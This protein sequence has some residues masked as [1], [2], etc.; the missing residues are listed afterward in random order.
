MSVLDSLGGKWVGRNART[1]VAL[2]FGS[3]VSGHWYD[4]AIPG[5]NEFVRDLV[6]KAR[7]NQNALYRDA[8]TVRMHYEDSITDQFDALEDNFNRQLFLLRGRLMYHAKKIAPRKKP[9]VQ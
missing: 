1:G 5:H 6:K 3:V 4:D 7:F 9:T 8:V 2:P